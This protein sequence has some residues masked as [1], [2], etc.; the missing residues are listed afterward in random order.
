ML[1]VNGISASYGVI[2]VLHDVSFNVKQSEIVTI[3]GSNG[4]GKSTIL[5]IIQGMVKGTGG[6]VLF[7]NEPITGLPPHKIVDVGVVMIPEGM[8]SFPVHDDPRKIFFWERTEAPPGRKGK[9]PCNTV[10]NSFRS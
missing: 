1:E 7:Q 3:L 5:N 8:K 6:R 9:P 4:S 10:T 2:P